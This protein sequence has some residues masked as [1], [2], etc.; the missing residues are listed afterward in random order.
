MSYIFNRINV[1]VVMVMVF[2]IA[3]SLNEVFK[4]A[5]NVD[6]SNQAAYAQWFTSQQ[7]AFPNQEACQQST[8]FI[9][10]YEECNY[11]PAGQTFEELCGKD[12]TKGWRATSVAIPT[13]YRAAKEITLEFGTTTNLHRFS[14]DPETAMMSYTPPRSSSTTGTTKTIAAHDITTI[15]NKLVLYEFISLSTFLT[16]AELSDET[17]SYRLSL[18][19]GDSASAETLQRYTATCAVSDCPRSIID[20]KNDLLRIWGEKIA[21]IN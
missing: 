2:L 8:G 7:S 13:A 10:N 18:V 11:V 6:L 21:G 12:N 1:V 19:T 4:Y 14:L 20:I 9:C 16:G 17:N 15:T 3:M 5:Q